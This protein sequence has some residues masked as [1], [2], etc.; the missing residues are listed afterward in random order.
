MVRT[1]GAAPDGMAADISL[2]VDSLLERRLLRQ[3]LLGFTYTVWMDEVSCR[4]QPE[5]E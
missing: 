5:W 4:V 1:K 2:N 3:V